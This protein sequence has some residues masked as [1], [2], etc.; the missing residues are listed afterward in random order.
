MKRSI[1]L[2]FV[3]AVTSVLAWRSVKHGAQGADR[4]GWNVLIL[5]L[6][7]TRADRLG[8]YRFA[9]ADTPNIDR[10]AREGV[11][12]EQVESAAP[13]TL[14]AHSSLF[15]GRFPFQHGPSR[16]IRQALKQLKKLDGADH[17]VGSHILDGFDSL[18][19]EHI[20]GATVSPSGRV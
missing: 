19:L 12:F 6:D 10:L 9:G 2:V 16:R 5:T 7:T 8:A 20:A 15:T 18:W 3:L 17:E 13:L 14:P 1:V 4:R 11:L